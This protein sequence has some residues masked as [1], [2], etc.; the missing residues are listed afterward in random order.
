VFIVKKQSKIAHARAV[1]LKEKKN[2]TSYTASIGDDGR[3][4]L[5]IRGYKEKRK[6]KRKENQIKSKGNFLLFFF[7]N[8]HYL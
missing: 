2:K 7:F 1:N 6:R 5:E 8:T 4:R 3:C